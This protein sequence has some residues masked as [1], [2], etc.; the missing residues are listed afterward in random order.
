[1]LDVSNVMESG[2]RTLR[3]ITPLFSTRPGQSIRWD[4]ISGVR[5]PKRPVSHSHPG[6]WRYEHAHNPSDCRSPGSIIAN[7]TEKVKDDAIANGN[8]TVSQ[9]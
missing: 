2:K 3:T 9:K 8:K 7:K 4:R 6:L 1:M 5:I